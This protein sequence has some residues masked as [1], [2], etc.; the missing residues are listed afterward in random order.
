V[1]VVGHNNAGTDAGGKIY[2]STDSGVSWTPRES[3]RG[4][5][6]VASSSDG[7]K[8]VAGVNGGKIYTSTDSGAT[9]TERGIIIHYWYS[10]ASSSDGVKLVAVALSGY[11]YTSV[12][13]GVTWTASESTGTGFW[14]SVASSSNG[15]KLVTGTGGYIFGSTDS[16][17][18]WEAIKN[19]SGDKSV[20]SS[21]DG[22][23]L[24]AVVQYGQI[25]TSADS[26][27]SWTARESNRQWQS[28][29]S[30]SDGVKLVAVV[31]GG[32][33]YTSTDSGL[34]WTA[35]CSSTE[36]GCN[37]VAP[38]SYVCTR[39]DNPPVDSCSSNYKRRPVSWTNAKATATNAA[40]CTAVTYGTAVCSSSCNPPQQSTDTNA[41]NYVAPSCPSTTPGCPGYSA[42][43]PPTQQGCPGYVTPCN[44]PIGF[45]VPNNKLIAQ[46][47]DTTGMR[48]NYVWAQNPSGGCSQQIYG[49]PACDNTCPNANTA[50]GCCPSTRKGC[51]G[52][53]AK[54]PGPPSYISWS[55]SSYNTLG[56]SWGAPADDGG[57]TITAYRVTVYSNA[58]RSAAL[59]S[60][61]TGGSP[62]FLSYSSLGTGASQTYY[63]EVYATN[64]V[65]NGA[66]GSI[67]ATT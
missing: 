63:I 11:I 54:V 49:T 2:T 10:V 65:G 52:F 17:V 9:W 37:Y 48:T 20:A 67:V 8:L 1:A 16:G 45:S 22:V 12:N 61:S 5:L 21:S 34:T 47:C 55:P 66:V 30:S 26:G 23:K 62:S 29:A 18:N 3:N 60:S 25:Y 14:R 57:Q 7:V 50:S 43:C 46:A 6:S 32:Q 51:P 13:S 41:C 64:S 40:S 58:N 19:I 28:V 56:V 24:V 53:V 38:S 44:E 27:L 35:S 42:P 4:W 33:I 15:V 39:D 59:Q 31:R 36:P